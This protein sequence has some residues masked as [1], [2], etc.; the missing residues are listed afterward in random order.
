MLGQEPVALGQESAEAPPSP[1]SGESVGGGASLPRI[2]AVELRGQAPEGGVEGLLPLLA[3]RVG[4][5]LTDRAVRETLRNL[6]ASGQVATARVDSRELGGGEVVVTVSLRPHRLVRGIRFE[7]ID[8][9]NEEIS[10][11]ALSALLSLRP[12]QPLVGDALAQDARTL[13]DHLQGLGFPAARVEPRLDLAAQSLAGAEVSF[14]LETGPR[15][16]VGSLVFEGDLG[17][18]AA[19]ELIE[20]LGV[21][22][23]EPV[24]EEAVADSAE[25]LRV[26]LVDSGYRQARV[27]PPRRQIRYGRPSSVEG[28]SVVVPSLAA[29]SAPAPSVDL[30]Y[31][32]QLGPKFRLVVEG[33][34]QEKLERRGLLSVLDGEGYDPAL[35]VRTREQLVRW[36]QEKGHYDV[37]V[38]AEEERLQG[39]DAK[40][41]VELRVMVEPGLRYELESF[42]VEG[43]EVIGDQRLQEL[44]ATSPPRRLV[45]GSGRLVSAVL[46][47][48]MTN[49]RSFYALEGFYQARVADPVITKDGQELRVA[50]EVEEGPQR[51]LAAVVITERRW[52][53][54]EAAGAEPGL[55]LEDLLGARWRESL[56]TVPGG[57][58]HPQ[59]VEESAE[60][61]RDRLRDAGYPW[62]QV[63]PRVTWIHDTLA[64]VELRL[65]R[66][67]RALVGRVVLRGQQHTEEPVLRRFVDLQPG[68]PIARRRLL[69]VERSLA[70]LGIFSRVDVRALPGEAGSTQRNVLVEV[71]EGR[72]R[73]VSYGLGYDSDDGIRGLL[74]YSHKNLWGRALSLQLD[75]RASER[76]ERYRI[77]LSQPYL[78]RWDVP[79]NY[80]LFRFDED[81][82]SFRQQ[83]R[84]FRTEAFRELPRGRRVALVYDYRRIDL[85]DVQGS[86]A[87]IDPQDREI[88]IN[89]LI[90]SLLVD[91]RDDPFDP[92]RGWSTALQL[93]YAFPVLGADAQFLKAFVQQT[94]YLDLERYGVLAAS[95]RV[96]AIEPLGSGRDAAEG[97]NPVPIGERF[98]AGGR[99]S[100]RAFERDLLG[101]DGVTR[102]ATEEGGGVRLLPRGGNA[103]LLLNLEARFPLTAALGGTAFLDI[104]NVWA[105]WRDLDLDQ[106]RYGLGAGIRYRSPIGPIRLEAGWNLDRQPGEG[107][108]EF[109]LTFGNPF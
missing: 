65:L 71:E 26:W 1:S 6:H 70:R 42:T 52:L 15:A 75:L 3:L 97:L 89:S 67:P 68:D 44:V 81:R 16:T 82:E 63:S 86:L 43:N 73:R 10:P 36:Y 80:T 38:A 37:L 13:Q 41:E 109:H 105:D 76:D 30:V 54:P 90:P 62:V 77:L 95:L 61:V 31:S 2:A 22:P 48:D 102:I 96:G 39:P 8:A 84:G 18:F 12:G 35:L 27:E 4:E 103:L 20:H 46:Q 106:I 53:P 78:G 100:H 47:E 7:G 58:Y 101:I 9:E 17:P 11:E 72:A 79:V 91:R 28:A 50:V 93:Q 57:P 66:G 108:V 32:L 29:L 94:A 99:T 107:S 25:A 5:P 21:A 64:E 60:L 24:V 56:P 59:R 23:G 104:G 14:V 83:S 49:L 34:E 33:A 87:A 19:T 51:R 40:E 88:Q 45:P 74:G 55:P 85:E 92:T 98:F 69:E